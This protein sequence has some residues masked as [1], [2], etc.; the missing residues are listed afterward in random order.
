MAGRRPAWRQHLSDFDASHFGFLT[1]RRGERFLPQEL[2]ALRTRRH[3]ADRCG[4]LCLA[5]CGQTHVRAAG[6]R[7]PGAW[8]RPPRVEGLEWA[9]LGLLPA[10]PVGLG[11]RR[12]GFPRAR[13]HPQELPPPARPP[14][15]PHSGGPIPLSPLPAVS[16]PEACMATLMTPGLPWGH[17]SP[18]CPGS[19]A[20]HLPM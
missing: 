17:Q 19:P 16:P 4:C 15:W 9:R 11:G 5:L 6:S 1:S 3:Q 2:G 8:G 18:L 12:S 14:A 10:P 20:C 13:C 7:T